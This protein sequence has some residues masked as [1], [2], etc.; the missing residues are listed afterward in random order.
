MRQY[1]EELK[2][3][4]MLEVS[5]LQKNARAQH[6]NPL[7]AGLK[8][9]PDYVLKLKIPKKMREE[10]AKE[11]QEN[12]MKRLVRLDVS[13]L[14]ETFL[15]LLRDPESNSRDKALASPFWQERGRVRFWARVSSQEIVLRP[16]CVLT[17]SKDACTSSTG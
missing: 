11:T 1:L 2:G 14:L 13:N 3:K 17:S 4:T 5:K 16:S 12:S 10:M 15:R 6:T 8:L 7:L 9:V